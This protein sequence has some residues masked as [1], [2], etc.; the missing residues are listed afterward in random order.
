MTDKE[1]EYLNELKSMCNSIKDDFNREIFN[2]VCCR[3]QGF[4]M[5]SS[6]SKLV[7]K[8]YIINELINSGYLQRKN[9][10]SLPDDRKVR[11]AARQLLQGGLPIVATSNSKG[12]FIAE[13]PQEI[14]TP[15][16]QNHKR[17]MALLEVDKAYNGIR[18]RL[19]GQGRIC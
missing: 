17:A 18:Q 4:K 10:G 15:Q 6:I 5:S 2:I 8:E 3:F 1:F 11:A 16:R 14:D 9:D 12:Y 7:S 19:M 13:E